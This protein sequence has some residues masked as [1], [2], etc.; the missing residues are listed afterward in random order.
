MYFQ[1]QKRCRVCNS[2]YY[3]K[4]ISEEAFAEISD[5]PNLAID[6]SP[7]MKTATIESICDEHVDS[8]VT[9]ET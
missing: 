4:L 9:T 8:E 5:N 1:F 7:I 3:K 2:V 6:V